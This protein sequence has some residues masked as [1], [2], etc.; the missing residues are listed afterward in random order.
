MTV[1]FL[2]G[3]NI[4]G[5]NILMK[6]QTELKKESETIIFDKSQIND[7]VYDFKIGRFYLDFRFGFGIYI[8]CRDDVFNTSC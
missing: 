4:H 3:K 8:N 7:N 2:I 6:Y 5:K 1:S